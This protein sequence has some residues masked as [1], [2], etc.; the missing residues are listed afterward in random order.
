MSLNSHVGVGVD[1]IVNVVVVVGVV[2]N[3]SVCSD[4]QG[5]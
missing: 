3:E 2:M 1:A 4:L 5:E